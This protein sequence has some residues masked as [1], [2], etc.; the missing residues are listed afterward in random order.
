MPYVSALGS[1]AGGAC[2]VADGDRWKSVVGRAHAK[3][4]GGL[5]IGRIQQG[6]LLEQ[7]PDHFPRCACLFFERCQLRPNPGVGTSEIGC[8]MK[9]A[10]GGGRVGSLESCQTLSLRT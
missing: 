7:R 1:C 10:A 3:E 2:Q 5:K 4:E 6:R 8:P 9:F